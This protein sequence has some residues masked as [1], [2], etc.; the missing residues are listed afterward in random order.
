M[1]ESRW[2]DEAEEVLAGLRAAAE[3]QK[4]ETERRFDA[5]WELRKEINSLVLRGKHAGLSHTQLAEALSADSHFPVTHQ[6]VQV[7]VREVEATASS[8]VNQLVEEASIEAL[9]R[10]H[11]ISEREA[12]NV[13]HEERLAAQTAAREARKTKAAKLVAFVEEIAE[14]TSMRSDRASDVVLGVEQGWSNPR[15]TAAIERSF[16]DYVAADRRREIAKHVV[17]FAREQSEPSPEEA[18]DSN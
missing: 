15:L 8:A 4:E 7:I 10:D 5:M 14:G 9:M 11:A 1:D 17:A 13:L 2:W 18:D 16:T 3:R 12:R 6:H